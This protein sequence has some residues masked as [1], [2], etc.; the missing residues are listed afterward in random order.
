MR[1]HLPKLVAALALAFLPACGGGD[2]P[3]ETKPEVNHV[4]L[5]F[6]GSESGTFESTGMP[7]FPN[8]YTKDFVALAVGG[9]NGVFITHQVL[10]VNAGTAYA[11]AGFDDF[12]LFLNPSITSPGQYGPGDCPQPATVGGCFVAHVR[13]GVPPE[14]GTP[15]IF[16]DAVKDSVMITVQKITA[17]SLRAS[18]E[19]RFTFSRPGQPVQRANVSQGMI[20]AVRVA[21]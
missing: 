2:G 7:V 19:G 10:A 14:G 5:Q 12:V 9:V 11:P 15:A 8:D 6:T 3:T 18:F 13:F 1:V 20:F 4:R 16:M 17:D 21:H